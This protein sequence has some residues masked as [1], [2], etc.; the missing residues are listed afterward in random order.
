MNRPKHNAFKDNLV[1]QSARG[2]RSLNQQFPNGFAL[3]ATLALMVLLV[4]LSLGL[5][6]LST[7]SLRSA[8]QGKAQLE[9]QAN[10]KLALMIAIGELQKHAGPDTRVTA[11]ADI[12]DAN[13]PP[14]VG[15]WRSWEGT[16]HEASGNFTGRPIAPDYASKDSRLVTWLVSGA[17]SAVSYSQVSDLVSKT[18]TPNSVELV[19]GGSLA[20]GDDRQVH[21]PL[22]TLP[23]G[24]KYAWWVSPENQKARLPKPRSPDNDTAAGWSAFVRNH[25]VSDPG[26]FGL[27]SLLD[28]ASPAEKTYTLATADLYTDENAEIRPSKS[29]HDLSPSS[30]GL[31]T[32]VATGGWRKDL[33]LIT[34]RWEEQAE[35][36]LELFQLSP[37]ESLL[38]NR[39][40]EANMT[41][42]SGIPHSVANS[43]P[44]HWAEYP[45]A[46]TTAHAP[47]AIGSWTNMVNW[48]TL[49]KEFSP[50]PD[51]PQIIARSY[52]RHDYYH[53]FHDIQLFNKIARIQ[54]I[55]SHYAIP[56]VEDPTNLIPCLLDTPV[57]TMW[58]PYN[59]EITENRTA[60]YR[61]DNSLP[62][63]L[64]Y[65][66]GGV[67][68]P[69]AAVHRSRYYDNTITDT[70]TYIFKFPSFTL[71]PGE[72]KVFSPEA[73]RLVNMRPSTF[74]RHNPSIDIKP[75]Y[76]SGG[77]FYVA[78]NQILDPKPIR[79]GQPHDP[80]KIELAPGT[81]INVEKASFDT[82]SHRLCGVY[83]QWGF[84]GGGHEFFETRFRQSQANTLYPP[85]TS[86][87]EVSLA[88]CRENPKPF[89]SMVLGMRN[90]NHTHLATKGFVQASPL[91]DA[92]QPG[93]HNDQRGGMRYDYIG[94]ESLINYAWDF[95]F[96]EHSSGPGDTLLPDVDQNTDSG[97][98]ISG[99][100]KADGV[101][102]SVVAE[103][104]TRP[105][106]SLVD[107]THWNA[108]HINSVPPF[109]FNL[110]GNSDATPLVAADA[111]H[112]PYEQARNFSTWYTP[113]R[114][115][116]HDDS[117]ILNHLFFDDWFVSSI[118]PQPDGFGSGGGTFADT[119][120]AFVLGETPL[121]NHAYRA[122]PEDLAGN[123]SEANAR[124]Q[125]N[126]QSVDS[127]RTIAS[128][129]EVE[130][131]FNVNSTSV[132][133]WRALLGHARNQKIPYMTA[134]GNAVL[135]EPTDHAFP[136]AGF[137]G[138]QKAGTVIPATYAFATE[139]TGYRVLDEDVLDQLAEEVVRQVRLRGPFLSLAEFVN[140]RLSADASEQELALSG[141]IQAALNALGENNS[142]NPFQ[143]L[144]NESNLSVANP[145]GPHGYSF[146][147]AAVGH[148]SY[149]LPG[150]TRQ[151]DVLRPLAP[152][153]SARDDTFT[154]RAYGESLDGN[155]NP[156]ARAWCEATVRRTKDFVDNSE[157]ADTIGT[158]QNPTNKV[159]GR[160]FEI[161]SFRWL[162]PDEV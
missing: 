124:F 147:Q 12:I 3:V 73:D 110:F 134:A 11:P 156:V 52:R 158:P 160:R 123:A 65:Q 102:R 112:V 114:N 76:R 71:K 89:L 50:T 19:A 2:A 21:V 99:F 10:A 127:W 101:P 28:D 96:V 59:V 38:F 29:F 16:N 47:N 7:I 54:F 80:N 161:I 107:L 31:L 6:S 66:I 131:M 133:A 157:A 120:K 142:V 141:A 68:Y 136:R 72:T 153:L 100:S 130:G 15:V 56:G 97:Y 98:I 44:Y 121:A 24:G 81:M 37:D 9:A 117:Y 77:G 25:S 69:Q 57:I 115:L 152:V 20:A 35:D 109:G 67:T 45:P 106:S 148:S 61:I 149:G 63:A 42:S 75:G 64:E 70:W 144:Q 111:V 84:A 88:E 93:H 79:S 139:F 91:T 34:E 62:L 46:A 48:A 83:G 87:A 143:N 27:E 86:L 1:P 30:I 119:Y 138:D 108:R 53:K 36:E 13:H 82:G 14:L 159:F 105:I 85:L 32:N 116:Q 23:E 118:A 140:R 78:L 162:H 104:P 58:N 137:A 41:V 60:T 135:S 39:P 150:W 113:K 43:M 55:T 92:M 94:G 155:G 8:G 17:S 126:V 74:N 146:P 122:I 103:V 95:S 22:Q 151:A 132:K 129:L 51:T 145:A 49:Y 5:L 26:V 154:I 128:R 18:A 33:S 40:T 90:A 4:I 125:K